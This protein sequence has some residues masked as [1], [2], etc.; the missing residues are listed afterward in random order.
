MPT[1]DYECADCGS[2]SAFRRMSEYRDPQ[3]CPACGTASPRVLGAAPMVS[4]M[5]E[6]RRSAMAVNERS[7]HA[8]A[9]SAE[10]KARHGAGCGCCGGGRRGAAAVAADGS[11]GFPSRRPW[12]ISH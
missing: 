4:G 12:M 10:Y 1:Y 7:A 9:G 6:A 5:P 8:P 11:R 3:P 2:F